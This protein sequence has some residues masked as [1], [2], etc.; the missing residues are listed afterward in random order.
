MMQLLQEWSKTAPEEC[1]FT[2][3]PTPNHYRLTLS[4]KGEETISVKLRSDRTFDLM[5]RGVIREALEKAIASRK[6]NYQIHHSDVGDFAL[7]TTGQ[8]LT[9][10]FQSQ[11]RSPLSA[12]LSAY[13]KALNAKVAA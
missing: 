12:L 1:V 5:Q 11:G 13:L 3:L 9:M 6:W 8:R 4:V 7:L 2:S 10:P